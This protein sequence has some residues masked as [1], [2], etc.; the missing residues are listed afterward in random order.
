MKLSFKKISF[1]AARKRGLYFWI[2][3]YKTL[4]SLCF[5]VI[6]GFVA[7]QWHRDLYRYRWTEG[8]RKAYLEQTA[9]ETAF[10]EKKFLEALERLDHDQEVH[11]ATL[12][13]GR[14]LFA[15]MRKKK[16]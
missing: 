10:Q 12:E 13:T 7:Y 4:F 16:P 2:R 9:K 8:Q 5:I 1:A 15:G 11:Q 6:T 14:D 3:H